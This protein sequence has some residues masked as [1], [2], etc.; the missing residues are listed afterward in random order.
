MFKDVPRLKRKLRIGEEVK[1]GQLT[2][3]GELDAIIKEYQGNDVK[4]EIPSQNR[5]VGFCLVLERE[6]VEDETLPA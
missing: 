1:F 3:K 4:V 5:S 2:L 6:P